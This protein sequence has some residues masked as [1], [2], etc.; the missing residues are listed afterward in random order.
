MS[1]DPASKSRRASGQA[2]LVLLGL[3]STLGP[4]SNDSVLPAFPSIQAEFA[5]T[6]VQMQQTLTAYFLPFAIMML[7]HGTLSDALGRKRMIVAGMAAYALAALAGALAQT[8]EALLLGRFLQGLSAGAGIVV[9]RA[10]VRDVYAHHEAQRALALVMVIFGIAPGLAPIVG[11]WLGHLFGWRSVFLFLSVLAAGL[12]AATLLWLPETLP[13]SRR[14]AIS[15]RSL[16]RGFRDALGS[17]R[18][19]L[20]TCAYACNFAGFFIYIVSAPAFG[21]RIL[22]IEQ[23]EFVW[24]FGPAIT[25]MI[26][27]SLLSARLA[28]R[29]TPAA[30]VFVAY[31]FM[32]AAALLNV[33][34]HASHPASLPISVL[35]IFV[36]CLGMGVAMPSMMLLALDMLPERRGLASSI[37][38]FA[39]S[40]SSAL[41]AGVISHQV[42]GSAQSLA[43]TSLAILTCGMV[44]WFSFLARVAVRLRS[45]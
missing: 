12:L 6:D 27:G 24:I 33:L 43:L 45:A 21:Y 16:A 38:G 7:L 2:L 18:F 19:V 34:Y 39:Q 3:L 31:A 5:V 10:I 41:L 23:T 37:I 30:T 32:V 4:F 15:L 36:Y 20:L 9:G 26:G 13:K 29:L 14:T 8:Y 42:S 22:G 28:G 1:N 40:G 44:F 17:A 35:P 25:G 11:G